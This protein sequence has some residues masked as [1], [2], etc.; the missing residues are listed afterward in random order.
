MTGATVVKVGGSLAESDAAAEL[1]RAL[2]ARRPPR[3]VVVPGGGDFADAVR[4]TGQRH[5]IGA[6]ATHHMALLAMHMSAVML[7]QFAPGYVV[8]ETPGEFDAAWERDLT[9][10]WA[11]E[12]MVLAAPDVP[13]SWDVTSDSLA[14]WLAGA[15]AASNLV[16][17]KSCPVPA[18][19]DGDVAAL[20][21]AGIVDP[22]FPGFVAGAGLPW[23][24]VSGAAAA[25]RALDGLG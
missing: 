19:M 18:A 20:A 6:Q 1:M 11:P 17:V 7:A 21:A 14:A 2:A 22:S 10:I 25:L 5:P 4:L 9:P 3:V 15:I 8:A 23:Q 16:L 13:A 12:R 24:V